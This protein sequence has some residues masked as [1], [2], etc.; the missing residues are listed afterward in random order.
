[1]AR[2]FTGEAPPRLHLSTKAAQAAVQKAIAMR[3]PH[4][5]HPGMVAAREI[6][7]FQK[8]ADLLIR[9]ASFQRLVQEIV[10]DMSRKSDPQM[11]ST[12]LLALQEAA[13]YFMVDVFNDTNLRTLHG[14]CKTIMV[15][16]LVLACCI[17]GI[18]MARA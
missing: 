16:D 17:Q 8:T 15:K 9:K 10:Q 4:H 6:H 18:G 5:W 3:K 14:K 11:Q 7:K 13:E 2:K 12:A 1:M